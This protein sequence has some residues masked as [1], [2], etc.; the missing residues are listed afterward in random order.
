MALLV[1]S[2]G[3]LIGA[4]GMHFA[5]IDGYRDAMHLG[6]LVQQ[7]IGFTIEEYFFHRNS[8]LHFSQ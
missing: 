1:Y 6:H 7:S 2:L 3:K 4:E 8:P 5:I